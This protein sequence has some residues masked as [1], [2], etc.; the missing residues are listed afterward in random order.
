MQGTA[1]TDRYRLTVGLRLL[2]TL[3]I[4]SVVMGALDQTIR[5]DLIL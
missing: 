4:A 3:Q 5:K 1:T 2:A